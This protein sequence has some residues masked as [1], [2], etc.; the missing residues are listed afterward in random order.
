MK[1]HQLPTITLESNRVLVSLLVAVVAPLLSQAQ[2]YS[3]EQLFK[4]GQDAY[5]ARNFVDSALYL[6]AY[7]QKTPDLSTT[8]PQHAEEVQK[9]YDYSV[10]MVRSAVV[11]R[12]RLKKQLASMPQNEGST[13]AGL[14][15]PPPPLHGPRRRFAAAAAAEF[16]DPVAGVWKYEMVSDAGGAVHQGTLSLNVRK[17]DVS[18]EMDTWDNSARAFTG[19]WNDGILLLTRD[20]GFETVQKFKIAIK[21]STGKGVFRNDGRYPDSGTIVISR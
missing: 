21:G 7:M 9:A 11:E 20:T 1:K 8:E 5:V 12:D 17:S 6:Y 15:M 13:T 10:R 19:S 14:E 18:G 4:M 3:S 16:V 2:V